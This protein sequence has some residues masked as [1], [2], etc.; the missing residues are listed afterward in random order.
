MEKLKIQ[1]ENCYGIKNLKEE[2]DF[3]SGNSFAIYAPNGV[4]KT[5]F[6][7]AFQDLSNEKESEDRIFWDRQTIRI[8]KDE[9]DID[10]TKEKVFRLRFGGASPTIQT[11]PRR[12]SG[13]NAM[14]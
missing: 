4:M 7:K 11:L 2:L 6:A 9:N 13:L 12:F 8:V 1:L 10:I 14:S 3:S 5:S